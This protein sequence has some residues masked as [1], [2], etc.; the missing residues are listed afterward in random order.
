MRK[1]LSLLWVLALAACAGG[2]GSMQSTQIPSVPAST[3]RGE[4]TLSAAA[5]F[6]SK[7]WV[8]GT[9]ASTYSYALQDLDFYPNSI[10]INAG[11]TIS[12]QI[13]SGVG[14]DGHTI[15]FVPSGMTIPSPGDPANLAP[16]NSTSTSGTVDG[17]KFVNSG[18][19]LGGQTYT[20]RFTKAGTYRI[21]CL[22]HEPAMAMTVTVHAAGTAY[23][24]DQ[25]FYTHT[26]S[27]DLWED[28]AA[29]QK[30]AASF[31]FKAFGTTLAA[32]I[33]P[34]QVTFPPPDST[35][36]R[37][38]TSASTDS[39]VLAREG[40]LTIKAGTTL[41]WVNLTSNEPH[42]V[43][44]VPAGQSDLP[45]IA[46]DQD[47]SPSGSTFDGSKFVNSGTFVVGQHFS[48]KFTKAGSYFYGCL[49][50]DNSRM[51]GTI[52]VTP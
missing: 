14:G 26:G 33:D 17:T 47:T 51:S 21:L 45:S 29:A 36:L 40:S 11:D 43:T 13:A 39:S 48:L 12:Y 52:T 19:E 7:N 4:Q 49:Y 50:H 35:I 5:S 24:H 32:G 38:L 8:V 22:F 42:T 44:V 23:P 16:T 31:P 37:Y 15:A 3:V 18:L 28:L 46:P 9:G 34:G 25:F 2:G 10:T 20:L 1:A 6:A 41:T 27:I 30:S